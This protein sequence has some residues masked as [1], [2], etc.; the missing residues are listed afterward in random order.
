MIKKLF[1]LCSLFLIPSFSWGAASPLTFAEEIEFVSKGEKP[2]MDLNKISEFVGAIHRKTDSPVMDSFFD[3][4]QF[5]GTPDCRTFATLIWGY[6]DG[7]SRK[8]SLTDSM[9]AEKIGPICGAVV[10]DLDKEAFFKERRLFAFIYKG[11]TYA[12]VNRSANKLEP[13]DVEELKS[14]IKGLRYP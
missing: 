9:S 7:V 5:N 3:L 2:V 14:F 8:L 6:F 4:Y 13:E 12:I 11:K 1:L 10:E